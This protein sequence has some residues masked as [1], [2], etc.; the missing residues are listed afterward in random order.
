MTN[1]LEETTVEFSL[2]MVDELRTALAESED[3]GGGFLHHGVATPVSNHRGIVATVDGDGR[4][5]ALIWLFDHTGGYALL[6][7]DAETGESEQFPLL[8]SRS[9]A[10][11]TLRQCDAPPGLP[12]NATN[13]SPLASTARV[14]PLGTAYTG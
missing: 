10:D 13:G 4:N 8:R 14:S 6:M 7:V 9:T 1:K 3:M 5:V 2:A 12:G 11:T